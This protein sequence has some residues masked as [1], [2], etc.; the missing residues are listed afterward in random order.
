MRISQRQ[1]ALF[2]A[3]AVALLAATLVLSSS[4]SAAAVDI[5]FEL[6]PGE[7]GCHDWT[8]RTSD[9]VQWNLTLQM[10]GTDSTSQTTPT[11]VY[12]DDSNIPAKANNWIFVLTAGQPF[13]PPDAFDSDRSNLQ[14][15]GDSTFLPIIDGSTLELALYGQQRTGGATV[16]TVSVILTPS[17]KSLNKDWYFNISAQTDRTGVPNITKKVELCV[18]I[19]PDP[20]YEMGN[21]T[22][23]TDPLA[24]PVY[25]IDA[26]GNSTVEVYFWLKNTG[27]TEDRYYCSVR[28]PRAD[29]TWQFVQGFQFT[30]ATTGRTNYT[31]P[32]QNLSDENNKVKVRVFV[33]PT[34][35]AQENTT[36]SLDCESEKLKLRN[37]GSNLSR[38][39]FP[40]YTRIRVVQY[41]WICGDE[42]PAAPTLQEG[43]PG[44]NLTFRFSVWNNGN[45]PDSAV[46]YLAAGETGWSL[47]IT[48]DAWD[49]KTGGT[50]PDP[51]YNGTGEFRV[52]IPPDT[53]IAT[54]EWQINVTSTHPNTPIC[55]L[56][57]KVSVLQQF[58]PTVTGSPPQTAVL[59]LEVVFN[60]RI[61]NEGNGL[62]S[63]RIQYY[64]QSGWRAFLDPPVGEKILTP[65]QYADF[66]LTIIAPDKA[67]SNLA[68]VGIYNTTVV[69]TS[70]YATDYGLSVTATTNL[71][72]IIEPRLECALDPP[73]TD[74]EFNPYAAPGQVS[75]ANFI[76]TATNLGNGADGLLLTTVSPGGI[77]VTL[78]PSS[79]NLKLEEFKAVLVTLRAS[80]AVP[81]G[82]YVVNITATSIL[83]D[84]SICT[85]QYRV[86]IF[87]LDGALNENVQS[88]VQDPQDPDKIPD[89]SVLPVVQ[90]IEG[91]YV[92]LR[93]IVENRGDRAIAYHTLTVTLKDELNCERAPTGGG[94]DTCGSRTLKTFD[95]E[96]NLTAGQL[97]SA[98]TMEFV[99]VAPD[100]LC[101]YDPVLCEGDSPPPNSHHLTFSLDMNAESN[102]TN[103]EVSVIVNVLPARLVKQVAPPP[104]LPIAAIVAGAAIA[105]AAGFVV[106]YRFLRPPQVD[107]ELYASIYGGGQEAAPQEQGPA[108]K[109]G[110]DDYFKEQQKPGEKPKQYEGM[111]DK[112]VEEARKLYG[113]SYG[114]RR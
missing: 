69:I 8:G 99:Y 110:I 23:N 88:F 62:D 65:H 51:G 66:T 36:V 14:A 21:F 25:E 60:F 106:W 104:P 72:I 46:A 114:K 27:N 13:S 3:G 9:R 16:A 43:I 76:L 113:D 83:N 44:D 103:N 30:N 75:E 18:H 4:A 11:F 59:G 10:N 95:L 94:N 73:S 81:P 111:S 48:P 63:L 19:P 24:D 67:H 45:G 55:P 7:G 112:Q 96:L 58:I 79:L 54:Y 77:N 49:L 71:S 97:G 1:L 22:Y 74:K 57:F 92:R 108:Q 40:P 100:Y 41:Y 86:T 91:Y 20:F 102:K 17:I 107:E 26:A 38:K 39:P 31:Q 52:S 12:V 101:I 84:S 5:R 64:N 78:A 42:D 56:R 53:P 80:A 50:P 37:D 87:N 68:S 2:I 82:L 33:P 89:V 28:V 93:L 109:D 70:V 61:S 32:G 15:S 35:R 90:Q 29:W 105:G 6:N 34:A 85:S 47:L 98:T